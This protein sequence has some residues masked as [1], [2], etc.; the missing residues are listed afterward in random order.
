MM[1]AATVSFE[2]ENI[3][4]EKLVGAQQGMLDFSDFW[5]TFLFSDIYIPSGTPVENDL[6]DVTPL[7]YQ[8]GDLVLMALCTS[9]GRL[10]AIKRMTD[11]CLKMNSKELLIRMPP[12]YGVVINPG[13]RFGLELS[14]EAVSKLKGGQVFDL[15]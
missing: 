5:Q 1:T 7:L 15:W 6:T 13:Q 4:E 10:Y 8:R 11:Y 2:P 3:L 12:H 9:L 14:E